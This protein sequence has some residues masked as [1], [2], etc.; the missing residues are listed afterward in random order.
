MEQIYWN[1]ATCF[2]WGWIGGIIYMYLW[3]KHCLKKK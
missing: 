1:Y 2:V 3:G